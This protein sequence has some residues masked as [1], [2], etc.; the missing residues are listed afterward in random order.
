VAQRGRPRKHPLPPV[1]EAPRKSSAP[2]KKRG[3][4]VPVKWREM[5]ERVREL[6]LRQKMRRKV[7]VA[8]TLDEFEA[9]VDLADRFDE[10]MQSVLQTCLKIGLKD[11][12]KFATQND[13]ANNRGY[14][15]PYERDASG[16]GRPTRV[17]AAFAPLPPMQPELA[18]P[19]LAAVPFSAGPTETTETYDEVIYAPP[20]QPVDRALLP[21]APL[22]GSDVHIEQP[23]PPADAVWGDG[24]LTQGIE[25]S[26]EQSAL[27]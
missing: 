9:V 19:H 4:A 1:A 2:I 14:Q 3:P 11:R 18:R 22:P 20:P 27:A 17:P 6:N 7:A 15:T 8:L 25:P 13:F 16:Y 5:D 21:S 26:D 10:S 12:Q 23:E 24:E